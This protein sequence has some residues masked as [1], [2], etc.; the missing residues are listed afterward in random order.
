MNKI[1]AFIRRERLYI[2]LLIFVILLSAVTSASHEGKGKKGA[3]SAVKTG[4]EKADEDFFMKP[5]EVQKL[6]SEKRYLAVLLSLASLLILAALFLGMIVDAILIRLKLFGGGINILTRAPCMARWGIWDICRVAILFCFFGYMIVTIEAFLAKSLPAVKNGNLRM[7]LNSSILDGLAVIFILYFTV[8]QYGEKLA[9]L[10][11]SLKNFAR[12]VFYGIVGYLA[13]V[14]LLIGT[15]MV[16]AFVINVTRYVPERQPV[17]ELFLKE[18]GA[19]FL[20]YT[21]VFAA[22]AGPVVEEL[23][24]RGFMYGAL[25]KYAGVFWATMV[26]AVLF[27]ALHTNI[28]GFFPI[29]IL[30]I[31]LAYV[32]EKTGTLVSSITLHTIHNI[33]MVLFVLL[34]KQ[35]K[36]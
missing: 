17:V 14:P 20:T 16:I 10:G 24:F 36:G 30:G 31:A 27:S 4:I 8:G 2:L 23:F 34:V 12:N 3:A 11:L 35:L 33:T 9:S 1:L 15:L 7:I 32:Y 19:A 28:V 22:F 5:A 6:L 18:R 25:R 26:T 21:T 13:V 29:M